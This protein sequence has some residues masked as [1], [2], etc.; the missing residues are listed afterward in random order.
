MSDFLLVFAFF[1]NIIALLFNAL[2]TVF[3]FDSVSLLDL[4]CMFEFV[5]ISMWGIFQIIAPQKT[6]E[7]E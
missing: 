3:I 6:T 5:H 2:D 4:A 1:M 7:A